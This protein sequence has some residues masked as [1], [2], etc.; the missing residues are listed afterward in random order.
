MH[1]ISPTTMQTSNLLIFIVF[2][3]DLYCQLHGIEYR[4]PQVILQAILAPY[5]VELG[6][7]TTKM[8]QT[9][10]DQKVEQKAEEKAVQKV[11]DLMAT[12]ANPGTSIQ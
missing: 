4:V 8:V 11:G 2:A 10:I 6:A 12:A 7:R 9:K 3:V 5:V 1:L